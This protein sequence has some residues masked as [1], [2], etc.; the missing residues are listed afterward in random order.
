MIVVTQY[1]EPDTD[2][3]VY[4][5]GYFETRLA[6]NSSRTATWRHICRYLE[7]FVAPDAAVLELGAGWC[8]FSNNI[9]AGHVVAMDI[10][11]VVRSAAA[12][13]VRAEVGDCTDLSRFADGS[14]D[15]VFASNLL[16]HLERPQ[17]Q[18][19]L[20]EA[21]RV[22]RPRGR[23]ILL[24]PNFRLDPGGYFDDY[25][26]VAIYTDR[27]L[28]DYLTSLG[29]RVETVIARFLPLTMKS[30][31]SR[32]TFLVPAYL[33]SPVKPLAGQMLLVA[34]RPGGA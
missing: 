3:G 11:A 2:S 25:T 27:S 34:G 23:L 7:R 22:L 28:N 10:D 8:D 14:F 19:L 32:L 18:R 29:W 33:R 31:A 21:G 26:H 30:R 4:R 16:E 6:P 13:H 17:A 9:R 20:A 1:E 15:V 5:S 24:Q 12:S